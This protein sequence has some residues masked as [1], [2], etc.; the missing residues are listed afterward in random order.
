M[1][2]TDL[3]SGQTSESNKEEQSMDLDSQKINSVYQKLL[4][5]PLS[6]YFYDPVNVNEVTDYLDIIAKPMSISE[7]KNFSTDLD[8]FIENCTL[9]VK[10]C[11]QYNP[12]GHPYRQYISELALIIQRELGVDFAKIGVQLE[13]NQEVRRNIS[14]ILQK[15][16]DNP[17]AKYF[18]EKVDPVRD[19]CPDYFSVI[20]K[21]MALIDVKDKNYHSYADFISDFILIIKNCYTY[22]AR[23]HIY[24]HYAKELSILFEQEFLSRGVTVDFKRYGIELHSKKRLK[25]LKIM[26]DI[27]LLSENIINM[28]R[29]LDVLESAGPVSKTEMMCPSRHRSLPENMETENIENELIDTKNR[30]ARRRASEPLNYGEEPIKPVKKRKRISEGDPKGHVPKRANNPVPKKDRICELCQTKQTPMWRRGPSGTATLCNKCGVKWRSGRTLFLPNGQALSPPSPASRLNPTSA[31][32]SS[33]NS[34]TVKAVSYKR[35]QHVAQVLTYSTLNREQMQVIV[36]MIRNYC[37]EYGDC[38]EEIELDIEELDDK[39]VEMMYKYVV[40][41]VGLKPM[42]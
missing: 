29:Q 31:R 4:A 19:G 20:K 22:N 24:R 26:K 28:R 13:F 37:P 12:P 27:Q 36:T 35:K 34:S 40:E 16:L 23:G 38:N 15:I 18:Y 6:K 17:C 5:N 8:K 1:I 33:T 41:T 32:P 39:L 21:P 14:E 30:V 11:F 10:N 2:V 42:E 25:S 7:L 3:C 9:I